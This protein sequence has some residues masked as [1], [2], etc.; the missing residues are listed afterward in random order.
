MRSLCEQGAAAMSSGKLVEQSPESPTPTTARSVPRNTAELLVLTLARQGVEHIF[1]NPGTDTAPVQEALA[2]C[3]RSG[4]RVPRVVTCA[5][6]AV[7]LAAAHGYFALTGRPQVVMVHVDVGTQNLGSMM[8]NAFRGEAGVV[9]VAGLTPTTWNG[10]Q[11]GGRDAVVHWHQDVPDQ[12]GI[13]RPYVKLTGELRTP[14]SLPG[15]IA[16]ALQVAASAPAGPVYLTVA[17]EVLMQPSTTQPTTPDRQGPATPTAPDPDVL[18]EVARILAYSERPVI[19]TSRVGRDPAAVDELVRLAE[20]LGAPVVDRR[21]R[22]NLPTTHPCYVPDAKSGGAL[23]AEADAILVVDSDV[24]WIPLRAA[25]DVHA[26]VIQVDADP[27][28]RTTPG[29]GFQADYRVQA[30]PRI[31]LRELHAHV[32]RAGGPGLAR[33]GAERLA[34]LTARATQATSRPRDNGAGPTSARLSVAAVV[35]ALDAVLDDDDIVLE[36][37]VTNSE[38]LR[39]HLRRTRP[40]TLFQSGGSGLGWGVPGAVGAKLAM[41][42]R[43]VVSVVGDGSFLFASPTASLLAA[44]EAEAPVMVVVLQNGGYAASSRPVHELFPDEASPQDREVVGTRFAV[45]PDFAKLADACHAHGEHVH[46]LEELGGAMQRA[47]D[48]TSHGRSAVVVAH[49][50]SPWLP[51]P[52]TTAPRG[53]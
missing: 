47:L 29:W 1:L 19:T 21:E 32:G 25:P 43:R 5:H 23:L 6:E 40:A 17:R 30:D 36:E 37:A 38:V 13:V 42:Q 52:S 22:L 3:A 34:A 2:H 44:L 26:T 27:V 31:A 9:V 46:R 10:E 53:E 24:P 14:E 4:A 35:Q 39:C 16:R 12:T 49:V 41:P 45:M 48:A 50:G 51:E 18:A 28:R 20:L 33:H 7:A 11:P 15:Q 8:H